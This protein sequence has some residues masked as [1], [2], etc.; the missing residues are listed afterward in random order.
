MVMFQKTLQGRSKSKVKVI[1][2]SSKI[3]IHSIF[4]RKLLRVK[5][6][7]Q[8]KTLSTKP[9]ASSRATQRTT[10]MHCFHF[11]QQRN[12]KLRE[13]WEFR[14][15]HKIK[16]PILYPWQTNSCLI[17]MKTNCSHECT[18]ETIPEI[19]SL[20]KPCPAAVVSHPNIP[21]SQPQVTWFATY[22]TCIIFY[23]K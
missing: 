7:N 14:P 15:S 1:L 10:F 20:I 16:Y 12:T 4:V 21:M 2:S 6:L 3:T 13:R 17:W 8:F 9:N 23:L 22:L 5:Y 11:E 18:R 19:N